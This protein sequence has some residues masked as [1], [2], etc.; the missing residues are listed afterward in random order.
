MLK[1]GVH[2]EKALPVKLHDCVFFQRGNVAIS[3]SA[4][5]KL[6]LL[7][8]MILQH[9]VLLELI[10]RDQIIKIDQLDRDEFL[11]GAE[12][13]KFLLRGLEVALQMQVHRHARHRPAQLQRMHGVA[14]VAHDGIA[15][16]HERDFLVPGQAGR[17]R[18]FE[19]DRFRKD[20]FLAAE[21][22]VLRVHGLLLRVGRFATARQRHRDP[23]LLRN[24]GVAGRDRVDVL[25]VRCPELAP[26][27]IHD[28]L[29][30]ALPQDKLL[31][32][33]HRAPAPPDAAHRRHAWIVPAA[34]AARVDDLGELALREDR[35]DEA[36][37]REIPV[38]DVAQAERAQHPLVL[39]VAVFVFGRAES[40]GDALE[41]IDERATE[42]VGRVDLPGVA[43]AVVGL[44]AAPVDDGVAHGFVEVV[45]GDLGADGPALALG[46]V[47]LHLLEAA[48][49]VFGR[50]VA[51][52]AG[53]AFAAFVLHDF[54]DGVVGVGGAFFEHLQTVF[55]QLLEIVARV[56]D[57]VWL[58][59]HER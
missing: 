24:G 33:R 20:D 37:P 27:Q 6:S 10:L 17:V 53:D 14:D 5:P 35:A 38:V 40:V 9:V 26:L 41:R 55:V 49:I 47:L 58:D 44:V 25:L 23:V 7:C 12:P 50:G 13:G 54:F 46:R 32:R 28:V 15:P 43:G 52:L 19:Q 11:I 4:R 56:R 8:E 39:R 3:N 2:S 42:V 16:V 36:Q 59:A 21:R 18:L 22:F 30:R 29:A 1:R 45:D 57:F 51:P 31:Q 48:E 34:H